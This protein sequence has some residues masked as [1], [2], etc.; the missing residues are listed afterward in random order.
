MTHPSRRALIMGGASVAL[1]ACAPRHDGV[2]APGIAGPAETDQMEAG[3]RLM[4]AGEYQL[5]LAAFTRAAVQHGLTPDVLTALG[6]A[7]LAL[8][9][10]GQ[11]E[12]QLRRATSA[13]DASP[14]AWNNLG[15]VL[16][17][18]GQFAQ[19]ARMFQRAFALADGRSDA[20]RDNLAKALAYRDGTSYTS[21]NNA[22]ARLIRR[23]T[24]D[25]LL[26]TGG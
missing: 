23:G 17:E 7:N 8:G 26:V 3:H 2:F 10:L 13:D 19:A 1:F 15:V 14:T 6:S 16:M 18:R 4:D 22:G 25:V 20:I 21:V 9:R 5:A 12:D 11:A 24:G